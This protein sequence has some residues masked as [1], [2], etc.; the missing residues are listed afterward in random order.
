M[1]KVIDENICLMFMMDGGDLEILDIKESD[2][3]IDVY[4]CYMGVCDGCMS[5]IIGILF[6]IENV[7]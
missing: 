5:V 6:V 1:D 2:D 4:I 3:Y 7:L